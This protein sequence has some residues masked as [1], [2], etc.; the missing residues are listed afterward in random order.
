MLRVSFFFRFT[1]KKVC[2]ACSRTGYKI[3]L[4][5]HLN[6]YLHNDNSETEVNRK[7][8]V[9]NGS[10]KGVNNIQDVQLKSGPILI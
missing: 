8:S 5:A 7:I 3:V 1:A 6:K 10:Y 4:L 2:I 9:K